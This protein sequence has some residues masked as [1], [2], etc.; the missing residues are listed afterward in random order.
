MSKVILVCFD[1]YHANNWSKNLAPFSR[2]IR[3]Q[4]NTNRGSL[5][6]VFPRFASASC[7]KYFEF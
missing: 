7:I 6:H 3:S 5:T 1:F 2:P 4:T